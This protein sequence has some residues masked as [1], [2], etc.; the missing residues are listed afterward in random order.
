MFVQDSRQLFSDPT[1]W[2]IDQLL[3]NSV[4]LDHGTYIFQLIFFTVVK[5]ME[6]SFLYF[7]IHD[8]TY[9]I[10]LVRFNTLLNLVLFFLKK[11]KMH[12]LFSLYFSQYPLE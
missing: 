5:C 3:K 7:A 12:I 1:H 10:P 9:H 4:N 6:M 8:N 11:Q 2:C